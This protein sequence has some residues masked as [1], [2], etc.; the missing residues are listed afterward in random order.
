MIY[1]IFVT[2]L[3]VAS[4]GDA[5]IIALIFTV[6]LLAIP[7]TAWLAH[8]WGLRH[9]TRYRKEYEHRAGIAKVIAPG[10]RLPVPSDDQLRQALR[11][12]DLPAHHPRGPDPETTHESPFEERR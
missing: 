2:G 12:L 3:A 8:R 10:G 5:I 7:L 11:D 4:M 1:P 9:H 6:A